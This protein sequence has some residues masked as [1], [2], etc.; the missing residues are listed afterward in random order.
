MLLLLLIVY[1]TLLRKRNQLE[2]GS[3]LE[4]KLVVE[5]NNVSIRLNKITELC[6]T[7]FCLYFI[8]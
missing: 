5:D 1:F 2:D 8:I 3:Q 6:L 4:P 7:I